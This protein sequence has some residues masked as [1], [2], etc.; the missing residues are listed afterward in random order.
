MRAALTPNGAL[1]TMVLVVG[2]ADAGLTLWDAGSAVASHRPSA[3]YGVVELLV[4]APQLALGVSA[5]NQGAQWYAAWMGLLSAHAIWTIATAFSED[6]PSPIIKAPPAI[7]L[8][9]HAVVSV[10]PTYVPLGQL[11]HPGVGLVGRF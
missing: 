2:S 5:F 8:K 1:Y 4:A 10:G 6:A 11:A 7:D 3:A 9:S